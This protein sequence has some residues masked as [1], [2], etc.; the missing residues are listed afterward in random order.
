MPLFAAD[1]NFNQHILEAI[2]SALPKLDIIRIID[3][4]IGGAK[5]PE[6]LDWAASQQRILI[7]HD[8][9]TVP[10]FAY[11]RMRAGLPMPGIVL[12]PAS[13]EVARAVEDLLLMI[14]CSLNEEWPN[15]VRYI[16][17]H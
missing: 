2:R 13:L 15:Q 9:A 7:T 4:G 16:P 14:E 10:A 12:V 1:E 8:A 5:D 11:D 6:I 17:L 3:V